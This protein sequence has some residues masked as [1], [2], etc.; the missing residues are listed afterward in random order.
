V[1]LQGFDVCQGLLV[2]G[3]QGHRQEFLLINTVMTLESTRN[4]LDT[5]IPDCA[6]W[7][8]AAELVTA[9]AN[10]FGSK[11]QSIVDMDKDW[12]DLQAE[13]NLE[14]LI[15]AI[16]KCLATM[17]PPKQWVL[18]FDQIN[19]LFTKGDQQVHNISAL[20]F[21]FSTIRTVYATRRG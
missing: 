11:C 12:S 13:I 6:R 4:Y 19:K 8:S 21:P 7:N 1:F 16:S 20:S 17:N 10:S 14:D 3:P 15:D 5:Y 2:T 18:V 9:I